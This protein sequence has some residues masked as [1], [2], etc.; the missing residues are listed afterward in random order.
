MITFMVIVIV[1]FMT[2]IVII[3]IKQYE[4]LRIKSKNIHARLSLF[5]D[6]RW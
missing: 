2:A 4:L 6:G 3:T 1:I 5:E